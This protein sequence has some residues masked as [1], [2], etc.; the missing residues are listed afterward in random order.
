MTPSDALAQLVDFALAGA[1]VED[2]I[3]VYDAVAMLPLNA[4]HVAR[5][6]RRKIAMIQ[7]DAR[8]TAAQLRAADDAQLR[9]RELL[10]GNGEQGGNGHKNGGNGE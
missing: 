5:S 9:F 6:E 1:A 3:Y 10:G 4:K 2:R 7:R 8:R